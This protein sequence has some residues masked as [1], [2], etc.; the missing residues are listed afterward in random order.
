MSERWFPDDMPVPAVSR[1]TLPW[2]QAAAEHRLVVQACG[3]CGRRQLP[4]GPICRR[5]HG[6]NLGWHDVPGTGTI[7]TYTIVH[8]AMIPSLATQLPYTVIVVQLDDAEDARLVSNLVDTPPTTI[9]IGMRVEVVWETLSPTLTVPRF[10]P[11]Q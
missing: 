7:Y 1:E 2:W 10:R 4:P 9:T 8:R 5:C 6:R 3:D 11:R